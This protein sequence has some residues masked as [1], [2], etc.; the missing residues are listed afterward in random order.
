MAL[1]DVMMTGERIYDLIEQDNFKTTDALFRQYRIPNN[2]NYI[3][4]HRKKVHY[5]AAMFEKEYLD[6]KK[7]LKKQFLSKALNIDSLGLRD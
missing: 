3:Q 7:L 2:D 4:E 6:G 5:Y 1:L